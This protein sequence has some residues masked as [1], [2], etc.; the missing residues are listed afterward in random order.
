MSTS[1]TAGRVVVGRYELIEPLGRGEVGVVW[2]ARD[3]Q[4]DRQVAIREVELPDV[5]DDAEQ[6]ALTEKVLREAGTAAGLRH[7]GVVAVFD[8]V[9]ED[10]R[11]F[12]VTELVTG[13]TLADGV[14][15]HGPLAPH[16]AAGL[17]LQLLDALAAAHRLH[18]V[19]RDLRPSN[20]F[21][22]A[23]GD[24]RLADFGVASLVD[25]PKIIAAGGVPDPSYL[26]PEQTES[27][28][29][30]FL[31]DLWSLGA[32]LYFA[33]EGVPPFEGDDPAAVVAAIVGRPPR[34]T[35]A[36]GALGPALDALL[37]KD[38]MARPDDEATRLLLAAATTPV[39]D[40][41]TAR[42]AADSEMPASP[43]PVPA[44]GMPAAPLGPAASSGAVPPA[45]GA[46]TAGTSAVSG[47]PA[48]GLGL[49]G[50]HAP[51]PE[52]EAPD[53]LPPGRVP[54]RQ[55]AAQEHHAPAPLAS[56]VGGPQSLS[57]A[58]RADPTHPPVEVPVGF[59]AAAAPTPVGLGPAAHEPAAGGAPVDGDTSSWAPPAVGN[60]AD[61]HPG[62]VGQPGREAVAVVAGSAEQPGTAGGSPGP[63]PLREPWF[64]HLPVEAV[65]PP[66]L[67][68]PPPRV[69]A[70]PA[71]RGRRR[72]PRGLW[73]A[74]LAVVVG[75]VMVALIITGGRQLTSSRPSL[76]SPGTLGGASSWVPY[77]DA[78]TGFTLRYPPNWGV[79]RTGNQTYFV[80]PV[81]KDDFVV[82]YQQPPPPSPVSAWFDQEQTLSATHQG[83]N[84]LQIVP[85]TFQGFPAAIWEYTYVDSGVGLHAYNLG[86][87][88]GR[89]GFALSFQ[90]R[91]ADWAGA[92]AALQNFKAFFR[93]PS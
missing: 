44:P 7:P 29:A 91:A 71:P 13:P 42:P 50:L 2:R 93:A 15:D 3:R 20:V 33:V 1:A 90:T 74:V 52:R 49:A 88:A 84:R 78:A 59:G 9:A 81:T 14:R 16:R 41:P 76:E 77:T 69:V 86:F 24:A 68:E 32:T 67:P 34:P 19:H 17:G 28:G 54:W 53:A 10:G 45:A 65:P 72:L 79:R 70:P 30:S 4:L 46:A 83:Y 85:T 48:A 43:V 18:L 82:G 22:T 12:V 27:A 87:A 58:A 40:S 21:L 39:A 64:F 37:V 57:P 11:P 25:D 56:E 51:P 80:D 38:A 66:P 23:T 55:M 92:Q 60:G 36:A 47:T 8:A 89:Y 62:E 26:A 6:A 63:A 31:S 35:V 73:L 75:A 5:L 61:H